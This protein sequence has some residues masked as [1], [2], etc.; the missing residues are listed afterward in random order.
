MRSTTKLGAKRRMSRTSAVQFG[1]LIVGNAGEALDLIGNVLAKA[2]EY[3]IVAQDLDG[4]FPLFSKD[5]TE[6]ARLN[7]QL[8]T[9]LFSTRPLLESS[10]EPAASHNSARPTWACWTIATACATRAAS[11]RG[12]ASALS[13]LRSGSRQQFD[14]GDHRAQTGRADPRIH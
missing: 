3:S 9:F 13:K 10:T 4:K 12:S 6:R 1:P 8:K 5:V 7:E 14:P 11:F 2:N